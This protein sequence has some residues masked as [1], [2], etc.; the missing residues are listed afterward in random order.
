MF[1]L[2]SGRFRVVNFALTLVLLL[3]TAHAGE[4]TPKERRVV[5]EQVWQLI[6]DRYY[7]PSFHGLDW[8]GIHERYRQKL[9]KTSSDAD[10]YLLLKQMTGELHDAHTRFRTPNER[11]RSSRKVA[12]TTGVQIADVEGAPTVVNVERDSEAARSG[13]QPGMV[14]STVDGEPATRRLAEVQ[15]GAGTSSSER[16]TALL[17]YY[18]LLDGEPGSLVRLGFVRADGTPLEVVL[19][20]HTISIAPAVASK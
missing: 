16:A 9:Q 17:S 13:V 19:K 6:R 18:R 11:K 12:T 5:F 7:D 20:R 8:N 3:G 1:P 4:F 2:H 15:Q 10:L 14:L